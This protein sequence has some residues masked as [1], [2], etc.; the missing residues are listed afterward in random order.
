[1]TDLA[2]QRQRLQALLDEHVPE[3]REAILAT[4]RFSLRLFATGEPSERVVSASR[5]GG[6]AALH[7]ADDWPTLHGRPLSFLLQLRLEDLPAFG[8]RD[9]L[10]ER[11]LLSFFVMDMWLDDSD[12]P[13]HEE[14]MDAYGSAGAVRYVPDPSDLVVVDPPYADGPFPVAHR[15]IRFEPELQLPALEGPD[16]DAVRATMSKEDFSTY[17]DE[18]WMNQHTFPDEPFHRLLGYPDMNFS[19]HTEGDRM[20]LQLSSDDAIEWE[21][22]DYQP[23][24]FLIPPGDLA[25]ARFGGVRVNSD[26]E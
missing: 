24:R 12:D 14:A 1:M 10:P 2:A 9:E 3:H 13:A 16:F 20:L 22:G 21:L 19:Y 17:W 18:V 6:P 26:Q 8:A 15:G 4:A 23:V 5:F 7:S 11:G 25:A